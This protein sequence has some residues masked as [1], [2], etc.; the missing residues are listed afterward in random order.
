MIQKVKLNQGQILTK[1]NIEDVLRKARIGY[2]Y[3][4]FDL[5]YGTYIIIAF[6]RD[7]TYDVMTNNRSQ[8]LWTDINYIRRT[9]GFNALVDIVFKWIREYNR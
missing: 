9:R 6:F 3:C 4:R 1:R 8:S 2:D 5:K 7:N